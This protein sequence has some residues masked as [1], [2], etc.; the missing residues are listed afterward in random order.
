MARRKTIF[1]KGEYYHIFN[2]GANR[3]QIFLI[4]ENYL[5]LL[6]LIKKY[7]NN[8]KIAVIAYC[9]MP[10]HYHFLLR[11]DGE[12][13]IAKFIQSI[14]N[15]YSKAFN[16][17]FHRSGTLF[18][19][20]YKSVRIKKQEYL[21]HLCRYI[22]RNPVDGEKPLVKNICDWRYSNYLEWINLR[23]GVLVDR[24]FIISMFQDNLSYQ[25]F[26]LEHNPSKRLRQE[27]RK[28]LFKN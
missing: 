20:P 8:T 11:Q 14:F 12:I 2:R 7:V 28:Y 3:Q 25:D 16:K 9:L 26:V 17:R 1:V 10:N 19:G 27:M 24:Q 6:R 22:H 4:E 21:I 18:E 23:K 13:S 15:S 5:F